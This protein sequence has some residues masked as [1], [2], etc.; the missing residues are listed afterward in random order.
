MRQRPMT[1]ILSALAPTFLL[2]ALG[3]FVRAQRIASAEAMG[4]VNRFGYF[5]LYPAFLYTLISRAGFANADSGPFL[6]GVLLGVAALIFTTL[7]LRFVFRGDGPAFTSLFQGAVRWNGFVVLAAAPSLYGQAGL[8][9]IGLAFGPLVLTIN[10]IS[11]LVLA[12]WGAA[13]AASWRA[14]FD[15]II[16]NPLILACGAGLA[17]NFAGLR[18]LG[19]VTDAL[20]LLG[21]AAMPVALV[22]VGA[23][24]DFNALRA[25]PSKLATAAVLKL[26]IAPAL[27][28][29]AVS[30]CGASPL[31]AAVAAGLGATPTAA[32]AYTLSREMGGDAKLMAAIITATTALSFL[33]LPIVLIF[34]QP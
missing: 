17:A 26:A 23:G 30:V 33:T 15:Q 13:P 22:C 34:T 10:V 29:S 12:R 31:A 18:S 5:V 2:I 8:D 3:Y 1:E 24:L 27:V 28:W 6:F 11:V 21:P 14:V 7:A 16:A 25:A 9:L 4:Q 19:P 20:A 32:A